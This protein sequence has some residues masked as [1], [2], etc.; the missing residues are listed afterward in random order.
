MALIDCKECSNKVS[1]LAESCPKCGA[2]VPKKLNPD[3]EHC[4]HCLTAVSEFATTCPSC[5]AK[6]GYANA[7]FLGFFDLGVVGKTGAKIYMGILAIGSITPIFFIALPLLIYTAYHYNKG[8][9]WYQS[10]DTP[11]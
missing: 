5:R 2:P 1:E 7:S 8:P 4:G 11:D 9:Y 6:K 10:R 3:A